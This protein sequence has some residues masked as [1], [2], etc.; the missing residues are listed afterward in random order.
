MTLP[1]APALGSAAAEHQARDAGEDDRP[2][3]HRAGLEGHV[4]DRVREAPAAERLGGLADRQDLRVSGRV[5]RAARARCRPRRAASSLAR[6]HGAD[7]DV[8][9]AGGGL[10]QP[11]RPAHQALVGFGEVAPGHS[12]QYRRAAPAL[13]LAATVSLKAAGFAPGTATFPLKAC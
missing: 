13:R 10:G 1:A 9:V 6:D 4:E 8:A 5:A 12:R 11:E 7:R 3:A 2:G